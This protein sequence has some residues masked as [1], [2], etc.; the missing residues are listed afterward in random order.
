VNGGA[1]SAK[2]AS[3][4]WSDTLAVAVAAPS[5]MLPSMPAP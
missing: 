4:R 3:C 2:V 1:L 5:F